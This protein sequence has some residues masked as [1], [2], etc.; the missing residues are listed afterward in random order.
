MRM[1]SHQL[2]VRIHAFG[3]PDLPGSGRHAGS[4]RNAETAN[5]ISR[6]QGDTTEGDSSV[7]L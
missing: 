1:K 7:L 5:T 2:A 4:A 6:A 3:Y